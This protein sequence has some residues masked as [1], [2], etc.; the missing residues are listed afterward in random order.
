MY[1]HFV[2]LMHEPN[3][4]IDLHTRD[5]WSTSHPLLHSTS[6]VPI[7][8]FILKSTILHTNFSM[9]N[10]ILYICRPVAKFACIKALANL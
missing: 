7:F 4:Y 6:R 3:E 2:K 8:Y 9:Q 5:K 1:L 10:H